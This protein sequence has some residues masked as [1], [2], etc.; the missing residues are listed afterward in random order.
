MPVNI[1][2]GVRK[3]LEKT[4]K[5][6]QKNYRERLKEMILFGSYA[7]GNFVEGS[8][9]DILLLLEHIED[10]AAERDRYFP[11]ISEISLE[12][13][14][15]VSIV[16]VDFQEFQEKRTPL[17]LNVHKEGKELINAV[18]AYIVEVKESVS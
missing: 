14:T 6:L 7:R 8:D 1:P 17:I 2:P 4:R 16:P 18:N 15:V 5:E 12:Y 10:A 3:I 9:I 11:V 13:D